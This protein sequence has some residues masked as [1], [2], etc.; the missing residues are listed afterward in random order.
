MLRARSENELAAT[1]RSHKFSAPLRSDET[2]IL[3]LLYEAVSWPS[4][5]MLSWFFYRHLLGRTS[6]SNNIYNIAFD[7]DTRRAMWLR[8]KLPEPRSAARNRVESNEVLPPSS[9]RLPRQVRD[10][11][12]TPAGRKACQ[13]ERAPAGMIRASRTKSLG[14]G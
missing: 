5:M 11:P 1:R 8:H 6:K 13:S 10:W 4:D 2:A 3:R 9:A 14:D 12:P 7:C